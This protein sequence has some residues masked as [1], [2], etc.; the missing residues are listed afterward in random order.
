[1]KLLVVCMLACIAAANAI[2]FGDLVHEEFKSF[3]VRVQPRKC[4]DRR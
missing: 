1:M 3:M 4:L 2:S